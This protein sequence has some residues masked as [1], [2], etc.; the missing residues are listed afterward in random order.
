M[1]RCRPSGRS[2]QWALQPTPCWVWAGEGHCALVLQTRQANPSPDWTCFTEAAARSTQLSSAGGPAG[3]TG[4]SARPAVQHLVGFPAPLTPGSRPETLHV[5]SGPAQVRTLLAAP[6]GAMPAGLP[7]CEA[8]TSRGRLSTDWPLPAAL[9][10]AL[11]SSSQVYEAGQAQAAPAKA[12]SAQCRCPGRKPKR[13]SPGRCGCPSTCILLQI[14]LCEVVHGRVRPPVTPGSSYSVKQQRSATNERRCPAPAWAPGAR[15]AS[16]ATRHRV[17]MRTAVHA[18]PWH[19][20][21]CIAE[22]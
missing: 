10:G 18:G 8:A 17:R 7:G 15:P 11:D 12:A 3:H 4:A 5:A 19:S 9:P 1:Q 14:V 2:R 22:R 20:P 16:S 21:C 6:A 13:P